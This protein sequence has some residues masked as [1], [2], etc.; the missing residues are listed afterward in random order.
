MCTSVKCEII[1]AQLTCSAGCG[2]HVDDVSA[3]VDDYGIA[4]TAAILKVLSV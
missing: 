3:K 4:Q 2:D 1:H